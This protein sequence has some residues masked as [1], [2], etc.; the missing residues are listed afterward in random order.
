MYLPYCTAFLIESCAMDGRKEGRPVLRT[1]I[2][3]SHSMR[4]NETSQRWTRALCRCQ[5]WGQREYE[6]AEQVFRKGHV[7]W[8]ASAPRHQDHDCSFRYCRK[9]RSTLAI[10]AV[11]DKLVGDHT[12]CGV[13]GAGAQATS[14]V[15][16]MGV[17]GGGDE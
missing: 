4:K 11:N 15:D 7:R 6:E 14:E 10:R 2:R 1:Q 12:L 8:D 16:S 9:G 13:S 3:E 17:E 5:D